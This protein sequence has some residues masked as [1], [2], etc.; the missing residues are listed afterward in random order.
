MRVDCISKYTLI[1]KYIPWSHFLFLAQATLVFSLTS[2]LASV[3][4]LALRHT[5]KL[6]SKV[7]DRLFCTRTGLVLHIKFSISVFSMYVQAN[8]LGPENLEIQ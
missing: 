8:F 5:L 4:A 1:S 3:C 2:A 6:Y 7:S